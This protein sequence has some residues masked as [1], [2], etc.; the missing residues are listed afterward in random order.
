MQPRELFKN[1][2]VPMVSSD[3]K[4]S[5]TNILD[6]SELIFEKCRNLLRIEKQN[7]RQEFTVL[8]TDSLQE[9]RGIADHICSKFDEQSLEVLKIV[10]TNES[11]ITR[12]K[13]QFNP[14]QQFSPNE[15]LSETP[16]T[17]KTR[18]NRKTLEKKLKDDLYAS[19]EWLPTPKPS[20]M[21]QDQSTPKVAQSIANDLDDMRDF[22]DSQNKN[23]FGLKDEILEL[24]EKFR[25]FEFDAV[26]K[27]SELTGRV[28]DLAMKYES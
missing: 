16:S 2:S 14:S 4:N 17:P 6:E 12:L 8:L 7:M 5:S 21:D 28:G 20:P 9:F 22:F 23:T 3:K 27:N 19:S 26:Q 11:E 10:K 15:S 13:N 1:D 25:K 18:T 24:Q